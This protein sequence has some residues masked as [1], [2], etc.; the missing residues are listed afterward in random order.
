MLP[1]PPGSRWAETVR[2]LH[3]RAR[4]QCHPIMSKSPAF[5]SRAGD[6]EQLCTLLHYASFEELPAEVL[7]LWERV[8]T[9]RPFLS[10]DWFRNLHTNVGAD[11]GELFIYVL[12]AG[13]GRPLCILPCGRRTDTRHGDV[14]LLAL[15][16]YYSTCYDILVDEGSGDR[17][18]VIAQFMG[19]LARQSGWDSL[20]LFP[21]RHGSELEHLQAAARANMLAVSSFFETANWS[22]TITDLEQYRAS[23]SSQMRSTLKRRTARMV[24]DTQHRYEV[25]TELSE[26]PR[27]V[28]DF[29]RCY[30]ASWKV[31]EPYPHFIEGLASFAAKRGWLRL[32]LLYI[33]DQP[34]AGQLWLVNSG[35]ASIYKLAYDAQF[36]EYSPGTLL[37]MHLLEHVVRQDQVTHVD[38]LTGDDGYKRDWM[39]TRDELWRLRI[40]N[41]RRWRGVVTAGYDRLRKWQYKL[42]GE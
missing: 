23:R 15:A 4:I 10:L 11:L 8:G 29:D 25:V 31:P 20:T 26:V 21:V 37:T 2:P 12:F 33:N 16:N 30:A 35:V 6:G 14:K 5:V 38:F 39:S 1:S 36:Q 40:C 9:V 19:A 41:L 22:E 42:R 7:A 32:G 34:A 28:A 3:N 18:Q 17:G 24:R 13:T 27:A